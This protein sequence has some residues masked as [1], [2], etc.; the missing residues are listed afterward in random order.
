LPFPYYRLM[1]L[2]LVLFDV[3][4]A[5]QMSLAG[6]RYDSDMLRTPHHSISVSG[7]EAGGMAMTIDVI[8]L[9]YSVS[10]SLYFLISFVA[11]SLLWTSIELLNPWSSG[12]LRLP[13]DEYLLIPLVGHRKLLGA[14]M[15]RDAR[16]TAAEHKQKWVRAAETAVLHETRA[17]GEVGADVC[18]AS[19]EGENGHAGA[20]APRTNGAESIFLQPFGAEDEGMLQSLAEESETFK[21]RKVISNNFQQLARGQSVL[22]RTGTQELS[23]GEKSSAWGDSLAELD[24]RA[25]MSWNA[26]GPAPKRQVS[27]EAIAAAATFGG[28]GSNGRQ[29]GSAPTARSVSFAASIDEGDETSQAPVARASKTDLM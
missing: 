16:K 9:T 6:N 27:D 3:I 11:H 18:D 8:Y 12:Q 26:W 25:R 13:A 15:K 24:R 28:G 29:G 23:L 14:A 10:A 21:I 2:M 7:D 4:F 20:H 17:G 1:V 19:G 5:L 22:S